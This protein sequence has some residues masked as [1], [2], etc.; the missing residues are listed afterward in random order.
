[1]S[2]AASMHGGADAEYDRLRETLAS[3]EAELKRYA[4][5]LEKLQGELKA[6]RLEVA[7]ARGETVHVRGFLKQA[8]AQLEAAE[9]HIEQLRAQ[10]KKREALLQARH[11][12]IAALRASTS[13]R[14]TRPLRGATY[15]A[16]GG[17]GTFLRRWKEYQRSG[18]QS[19]APAQ[20]PAAAP[21]F[22]DPNAAYLF[23]P[24][25]SA[26]EAGTV[27]L[28]ELYRLSRSL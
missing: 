12:D 6:S 26:D 8:Q 10:A 21:G 16:R 28:N 5:T 11:D 3:T 4:S 22:E 24:A 9:A 23:K 25:P 15:L 18:P 2:D 7:G 1:M 19:P 20:M 13:W 17:V 27:T 14:L